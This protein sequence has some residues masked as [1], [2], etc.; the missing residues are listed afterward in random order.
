MAMRH[1]YGRL[2]DQQ[3]CRATG[4]HRRYLRVDSTTEFFVSL[5]LQELLEERALDI[6]ATGRRFDGAWRLSSRHGFFCQPGEHLFGYLVAHP[7]GHT[8]RQIDL[9]PFR[10]ERGQFELVEVLEI[11]MDEPLYPTAAITVPG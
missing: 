11:V 3:I 10:M 4:P 8:R 9:L 2:L 7:P 6:G 1:C 5:P